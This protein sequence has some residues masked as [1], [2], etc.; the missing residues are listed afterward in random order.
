MG[1]ISSE[2]QL[3]TIPGGVKVLWHPLAFAC[4]LHPVKLSKTRSVVAASCFLLRDLYPGRHSPASLCPVSS[5]ELRAASQPRGWIFPASLEL[6]TA[7]QW[8][9]MNK[10]SSS[11]ADLGNAE[12]MV[13]QEVTWCS[14]CWSSSGWLLPPGCT[15]SKFAV[16]VLHC[17][18]ANFGVFIQTPSRDTLLP[19]D[20]S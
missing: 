20:Q 1:L 14:P 5:E 15:A 12:L 8:P 2:S 6:L 4:L 7:T 9:Q 16:A 13:V 11:R 17:W 3:Q 10:F 18:H 19:W